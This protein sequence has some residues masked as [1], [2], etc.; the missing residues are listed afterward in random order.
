VDIRFKNLNPEGEAMIAEVN[1]V[2]H[3]RTGNVL[4]DF[5][6]TSCGPCRAMNPILEEISKE[7]SQLKIAKVDVT[8]NPDMTQMFGVMS[9]PTVIFLKDNK[10]QHTARGLQNKATLK[11]MV[12]QYIND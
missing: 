4:V 2:S 10:V 6:T 11:S 1:D 9:V 7:F 3:I 5:Y 12:M 8:Q